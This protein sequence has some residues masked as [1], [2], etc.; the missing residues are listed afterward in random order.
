MNSYLYLL[1][2]SLMGWK[3]EGGLLP[4]GRWTY[5][6]IPPRQSNYQHGASCHPTRWSQ[7]A[8]MGALAVSYTMLRES[9]T[10][11]LMGC[12]SLHTPQ[13]CQP[14]PGQT[15]LQLRWAGSPYKRSEA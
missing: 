2:P 6:R 9:L 10:P 14:C 5:N 1:M 15:A 4:Q 11:L 7:Q 13:L 3:P 12:P 8:T